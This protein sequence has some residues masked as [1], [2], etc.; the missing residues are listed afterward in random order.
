MS[1]YAPLQPG[2][3]VW[4]HSLHV[5]RQATFVGEE[6]PGYLR[7]RVDTPARG[8]FERVVEAHLV[9]RRGP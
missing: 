3:P 1:T 4:W 2:D 7:V 9:T 8:T 5:M 6:R